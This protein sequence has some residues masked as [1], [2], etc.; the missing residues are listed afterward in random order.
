[1][2]RS[3]W[4]EQVRVLFEPLD[5]TRARPTY[6]QE[7]SPFTATWTDT[8]DLLKREASLI[9]APEVVLCVDAAPGNMRRDGGIRADAVVRQDLVE[10]YLPTSDAGTSL[11][12]ECGRY[13]GHRWGSSLAGWQSNVR[14]IA[15]GM[16][17]LRKVKRYGLGTG[18]EQYRGFG[19]LPPGDPIAL[20]AAMTL[21]EAARILSD[22]C[23][24][25]FEASD[26]L[27]ETADAERPWIAD[28][29][30]QAAKRHHPDAGGNPETFRLLTQARDLLLA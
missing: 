13:T 1:M 3:L 5:L 21:D 9:G 17:A 2:T 30:R 7:G 4:T 16:E 29:Y 12:F 22:G 19:A 25:M 26:L 18:N 11:R 27:A 14:A 23:D 6:E 10:V 24:G 28:A 8:V 15:L 20:G